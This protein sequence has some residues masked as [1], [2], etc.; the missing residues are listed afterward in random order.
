MEI[1]IPTFNRS[2][3]QVTWNNLPPV[4]ANQTQLVVQSGDYNKNHPAY[5][6]YGAK[7]YILP[8]HITNIGQTRQWLI[9]HHGSHILMLDDDLDFAVRRTDDPTKFRPAT[10][11]D[12]IQMINVIQSCLEEGVPLVGVSS[13]E[14]GNYDTS[15]FKTATRQ[16]RVHGV[17]T[18]FFR[19]KNIRYDRIP[20]MEDFD[21]TLQV[22]EA[23]YTNRVLN[24]WVHNQ[25]GGSNAKGG[26]STT[27]TLEA[28]NEAAIELKKLH[29][30]FIRLVDK[31]SGNWGGSRIDVHVSW[32]K[33]YN[34]YHKS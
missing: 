32:K 15:Q 25:R 19:E 2:E 24:G 9:T 34:E 4:I 12:V 3:N 16:L 5:N 7:L 10:S 33:A 20:F 29:P 13:R 17:N 23:G 14:G 27:R 1:F 6:R 8:P 22:L 30:K 18:T 26:C 11:T 28:H 21:A 31:D